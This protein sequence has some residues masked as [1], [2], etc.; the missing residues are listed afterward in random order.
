MEITKQIRERIEALAHRNGGIIT[1][2]AVVDDARDPQSPLHGKFEWDQEKAAY[3]HWLNVARDII[4]SVR[5]TITT[6]ATIVTSVAYVRDPRARSDEQG[7]MSVVSMRS[8]HDLARDAVLQ[9]VSRVEAA[10]HRAREVASVLN[11]QNEVESLITKAE[12]L[13][14]KAEKSKK[15]EHRPNA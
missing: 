8:D 9:E 14:V 7:Y 15:P 6:D 2:A 5:V 3:Q 1:P 10:L 11:L 12:R 4:R 13:R